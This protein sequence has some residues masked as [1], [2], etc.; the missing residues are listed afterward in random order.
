[1]LVPPEKLEEVRE[2]AGYLAPGGKN[3]SV[4]RKR[5]KLFIRI[6]DKPD[7][8]FKPSCDV[9]FFSL[10][11]EVCPMCV[12][13]LLTGIGYDGAKGLL[14]MKRKGGVTIAESEES[15]IVFGMPKTAIEIGAAQYILPSWKIGRFLKRTVE[16]LLKDAEERRTKVN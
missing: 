12:G 15:A 13:V 8:L 10:A 1:M 9:L 4:E 11:E 14:A 5:G 16:K 2:Y 6:S 3:M 7:T